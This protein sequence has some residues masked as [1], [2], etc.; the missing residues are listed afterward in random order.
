MEERAGK[1]PSLREV[2]ALMTPENIAEFYETQGVDF[3][4]LDNLALRYLRYLRQHGPA[5]EA[6]LS[7]ALGLTHK[8]DSVEIS[9]YLIRLG[10]IEISSGGRRLTREGTKYL[11]SNPPP[12]LRSRISRAI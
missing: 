3:N 8:Q 12:D 9:E 5:S 1:T 6:T 2:A 4:G 10:L 11:N 7:Q